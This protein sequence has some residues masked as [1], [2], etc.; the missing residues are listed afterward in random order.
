MLVF[1]WPV[2][3]D[4]EGERV[5]LLI[6]N[7]RYDLPE[8]A[9]RNPENDVIALG[10]KL[11]ALGFSVSEALNVDRAGM[12]T[13]LER[14][15]AAADHAEIALFFFAGH[16]V[17]VAGENYLIATEFD[18]LDEAELAQAAVTMG[19]VR[20]VFEAARP[21]VGVLILDACRNNPFTESGAAARGLVRAKG[22]AGLLYAYATDP[23]NVAYD[24]KGAN[25][26]FTGSL[27]EQIGT[28]GIDLRIMFGRVRQDVVLE[29]QGQQVPWVEEAVLGEHYLAG[30]SAGA[31]ID[32][33][34]ASELQIW[35]RIFDSSEPEPFEDYLRKYPDG[36]FSQ[37]A[38]DRISMLRQARL[39]GAASAQSSAELLA[40]AEPEPVAAALAALGYMQQARGLGDLALSDLARAFSAYRSQLSNPDAASIDQLYS[41]AARLSMFL[42][43]ATAQR[44]RT[45]LVALKSVERTVTIADDALVQIAEIAR[46]DPSA[47]PVLEAARADRDAIGRSHAEILLRL[48]QSRTYYHE[49][50]NRA[51]RFI[52]PDVTV[53]VL[54]SRRQTRGI[55]DLERRLVRDAEIFLRHV[56]EVREETEGSYAWLADF[57]P[58]N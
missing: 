5:A 44:I 29:T 22:G 36:L 13:A 58:I 38:R 24:G 49:L 47:L 21:E 34:Y 41:D 54:G 17:Q 23:G 7:A 8:L 10:E 31:S 37:F 26:V 57:L 12:E 27:L 48:D 4:A 19:R 46:T 18:R 30:K 33:A 1:A 32:D 20:D 53:D 56:S 50:L 45:D 42:A 14:F 55:T 3:A 40:Q 11:R 28:P 39:A 2:A 25:S 6:G 35:R 9:L 43:A 51:A 16:G 15:A 52:P